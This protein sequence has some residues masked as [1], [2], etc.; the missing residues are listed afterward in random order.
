M[1]DPLTGSAEQIAETLHGFADLGVSHV[2]VDIAP[3]TPAALER[4]A[5]SVRLY[6][7]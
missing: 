2:M 7:G 3:H 4:F 1:P 6:R 5:Q